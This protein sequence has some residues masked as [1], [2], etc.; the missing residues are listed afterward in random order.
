MFHNEVRPHSALEWMTPIEYAWNT[1]DPVKRDNQRAGI[2]QHWPVLIR[3]DAQALEFS[4]IDRF[5][6]GGEAHFITL[7]E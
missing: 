3:G 6:F 7:I 5:G 2:F 4:N 1:G